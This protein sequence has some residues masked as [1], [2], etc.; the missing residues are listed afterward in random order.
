MA[1]LYAVEQGWADVQDITTEH[2]EDHPACLREGIRRFWERT[3]PEPRKLSRGH[4]NAQ[5]RRLNRFFN[6]LLERRP[7]VAPG[8]V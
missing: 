2:I 5:Y 7:G 4:T 8:I 3:C 6:W 1:A